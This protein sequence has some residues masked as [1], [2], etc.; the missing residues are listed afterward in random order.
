MAVGIQTNV[1][2]FCTQQKYGLL[3]TEGN[4]KVSLM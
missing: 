1:W 3:E 2:A 4:G